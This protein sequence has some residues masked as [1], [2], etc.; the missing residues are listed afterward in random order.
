MSTQQ[1]RKRQKIGR[2]PLFLIVMVLMSSASLRLAAGAGPAIAQANRESEKSPEITPPTQNSIPETMVQ[3]TL[4]KPRNRAE[5]ATLLEALQ[6]REL[7]LRDQNRQMQMR[8]KALEVADKE[9]RRRMHDLEQLEASLRRTL[10]LA[11]GAAEGDL[12]QLTSVYENM[13]AKD[14]AALFETMD[15][16]FAAGFLGRM[17]PDTAAAIMAGL[18]PDAAYTISIILAGRNAK[19]PKN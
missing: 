12:V 4:K 17:R 16:P 3:E 14:A 18:T 6:S 2:G 11:D 19:A 9:V 13:K 1:G 15:P 7:R 8:Q 10:S 5:T